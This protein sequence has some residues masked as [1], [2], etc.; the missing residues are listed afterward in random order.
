MGRLSCLAAEERLLRNLMQ[1]VNFM[2]PIRR[3]LSKELSWKSLESNEM[4]KNAKKATKI[5]L[6]ESGNRSTIQS[7]LCT[8]R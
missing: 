4:Y 2:L 7:L 5:K 3:W 6:G 8:K 1:Y